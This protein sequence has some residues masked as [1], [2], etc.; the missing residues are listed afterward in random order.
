MSN[1]QAVLSSLHGRPRP[2]NVLFG[3]AAFPSLHV[4]FQTLAFLW[5]RRLTKWGGIV[6]GV[7]AGFIFIGSIV[8]GWHYFVDGIAG[9]ALAW[10]CYSAARHVPAIRA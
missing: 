10:A 8:T 5:M 3:I 1:Y 6:F 4:G 9:A 7:F 2:I